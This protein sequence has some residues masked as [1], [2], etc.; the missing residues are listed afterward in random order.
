[1][2]SGDEDRKVAQDV[3]L[4]NVLIAA[5]H[6]DETAFARLFRAVQPS[7][8]AFLRGLAPD[9]AEDLAAETWLH[10]VR[11]LRRFTG[12]VAG[13]RGWV[14]TIA[15]HR[16]A[17]HCRALRRRPQQVSD[18]SLLTVAA[19]DRVNDAVEEIIST[20]WALRLI[21]TLPP[22][23]AEVILLRVVAGLDVATTAAVVGKK[24][25]AVRVLAH[26]GLRRLA[27]LL[28]EP[29]AAWS[30]ARNGEGV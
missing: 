2:L 10:V 13:F 26:R 9:A 29:A 18:A 5:Q 24:P 12:D 6:G 20:E 22:D 15:H 23:Q 30:G 1:L 11:G 19:G 25:G 7:L 28:E 21:G 14:F 17:D 8:L 3:E 27:A 16:W 4:T